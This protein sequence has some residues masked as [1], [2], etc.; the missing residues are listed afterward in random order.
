VEGGG[1]G[2]AVVSVA[3]PAVRRDRANQ[4]AALS[5]E[6]RELAGVVIVAAVSGR[7]VASKNNPG[8]L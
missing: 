7:A 3:G 4:A 5:E 8:L 6:R 1:L 2:R